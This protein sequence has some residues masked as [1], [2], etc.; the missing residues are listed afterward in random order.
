MT[1]MYDGHLERRRMLKPSVYL[2]TTMFNYYFDADRDAHPATVAFFRAIEIGMY[3]A[4]TSQYTIDELLKAPEPKRSDMFGLIEKCGV[5]ILEGSDEAT[6]LADVYLQ[7]EGIPKKKRLDARH[8]AIA[9]A[10]RL[11]Y[12]ELLKTSVF[13]SLPL[14]KGNFTAF[15]REIAGHL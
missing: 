2:E 4:Y 5:I 11:Q 14:K 3:E 7:H 10:N 8:I 13:R 12:R 9:S 15:R 6:R 1:I